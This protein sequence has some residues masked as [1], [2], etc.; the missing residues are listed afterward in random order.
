MSLSPTVAH[1]YLH[2]TVTLCVCDIPSTSHASAVIVQM[3]CD[4][5]QWQ[6]TL[7]LGALRL[8]L[9]VEMV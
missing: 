8:M 6:F 1:R 9:E 4:P 5:C 2:L 3:H 7:K